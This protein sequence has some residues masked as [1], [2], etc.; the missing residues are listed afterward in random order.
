[1]GSSLAVGTGGSSFAATAATQLNVK[2][3]Y[4]APEFSDI[5]AWINSPPLTVAGLRGKV[6]LVNF[7]T[8]GCINCV[9][10][11]PWTKDM[12][13]KYSGK[14]L[15]IVGVHRPE[16]GYEHKLANVKQAIAEKSILYPVAI[17]NN[18]KTWRL[19]ENQFWPAFYFVDKHG[20]VRHRHF[21][22]GRYGENERVV[23]Q[24]LA[25]SA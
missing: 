8:F 13:A 24:L 20:F 17:D 5:E 21:G 25:E 7:W 15:T 1:M 3:P 11:M 2:T 12:H 9:R 22:E 6:V 16:F 10:T 18:A 19:Y 23:Q 14:G 4:A